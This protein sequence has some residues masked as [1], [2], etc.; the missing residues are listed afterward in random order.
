[1]VFVIGQS[2]FGDGERLFQQFVRYGDQCQFLALSLRRYP[3]IDLPACLVVLTCR[4]AAKEQEVTEFSIADLANPAAAPY[5][6]PGF[7]YNRR[8]ARI[9]T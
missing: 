6:A 2:R 3:L 8:D 7:P 9:A 1:M 4:E 5:T